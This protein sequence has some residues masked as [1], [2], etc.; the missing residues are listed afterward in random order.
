[1]YL[2]PGTMYKSL[3]TKMKKYKYEENSIEKS[4]NIS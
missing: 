2:V 4:T 3:I 1:M